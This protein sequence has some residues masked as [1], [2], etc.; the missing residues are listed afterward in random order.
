M[1]ELKFTTTAN[2]KYDQGKEYD[3]LLSVLPSKQDEMKFYKSPIIQG[4][5]KMHV[6]ELNDISDSESIS[7]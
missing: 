2:T 6:E 1:K 3:R 4:F 5:N 7:G